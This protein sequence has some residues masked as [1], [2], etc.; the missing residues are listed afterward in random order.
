MSNYTYHAV[1]SANAFGG[2]PADYY[3][4]HRWLDRGRRGTDRLL[5]R[6]LAHHTQG[7][8]DAVALFGDVITSSAG[9]KV[10]TSLLAHQHII[11][12]LGFVPVLE[13]YMELLQCPRW[14]SKPAKLL[15]S[16]LLEHPALHT[17]NDN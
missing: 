4:L 16:K 8:D 6:M 15:H 17:N 3:E 7:I 9:R 10:P 1:S 14:A 5:H 13:H 2:Q 12:D 11:E